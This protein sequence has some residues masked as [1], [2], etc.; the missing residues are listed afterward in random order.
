MATGP[1]PTAATG[2]DGR[3]ST[4]LLLVHLVMILVMQMPSLVDIGLCASDTCVCVCVCVL[5]A[6]LERPIECAL[7]DHSGCRWEGCVVGGCGKD[8][9]R[10]SLP[11]SLHVR[12]L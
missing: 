6:S 5:Y 4:P 7:D 2:V 12:G 10:C 1:R 9:R 11:A 8:D 3:V